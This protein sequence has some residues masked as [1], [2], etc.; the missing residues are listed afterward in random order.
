MTSYYLTILADI[1]YKVK[2]MALDGK[3]VK[4]TV[5]DT[6]TGIRDQARI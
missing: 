3:R 6:G 1:E 2:T 5:C 4:L